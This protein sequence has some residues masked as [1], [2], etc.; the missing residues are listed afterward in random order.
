M[1]GPP[2]PEAPAPD[3]EP[4]AEAPAEP[5][6][7]EEVPGADLPPA[8]PEAPWVPDSQP[9]WF[10]DIINSFHERLTKLGG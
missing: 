2:E 4:P 6:A 5:P 3:A 1:P 9:G 7:V 10:H 8:T